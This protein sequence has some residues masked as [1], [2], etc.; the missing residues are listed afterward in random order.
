MEKFPPVDIFI[1]HNSPKGV[2]ERDQDIHQ[3]FD[4]FNDYIER[5]NPLYFI[6]GHQHTNML[7]QINNTRI[8]SVYGEKALE[9]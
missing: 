9:L 8:L 6:H 1:A 3:G 7:S 4:A 5:A 2:H